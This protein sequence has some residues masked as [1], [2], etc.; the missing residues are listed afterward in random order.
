MLLSRWRRGWRD[1]KLY[2][3]VWW[4]LKRLYGKD[5]RRYYAN[6]PNAQAQYDRKDY[7]ARL[8]SNDDEPDP[9]F[10]HRTYHH[11]V[12]KTLADRRPV[13]NTAAVLDVREALTHL[14][15]AQRAA[16]EAVCLEGRDVREYA[17]EIGST[18]G[19][20]AAVLCKAKKKLAKLLEA[21]KE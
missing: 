11:T 3:R 18:P 2:M 7:L 13:P 21:Y 19:A 15:E 14:S 8:G 12:P 10:A 4:D 16:V 17:E 5:W 6:A 20:V 1:G 9:L